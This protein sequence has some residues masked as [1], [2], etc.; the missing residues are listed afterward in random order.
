MCT[1]FVGQLFLF[2][3]QRDQ[4]PWQNTDSSRVH[5]NRDIP[6]VNR[7]WQIGYAGHVG[8]VASQMLLP[9]DEHRATVVD[10]LK[11]II[12]RQ[13]LTFSDC[14]SPSSLKDSL[15]VRKSCS[16]NV[17]SDTACSRL[18]NSYGQPDVALS[19]DY[20]SSFDNSGPQTEGHSNKGNDR[21]NIS[22]KTN[23]IAN[24]YNMAMFENSFSDSAAND[25]FESDIIPSSIEKFRKCEKWNSLMSISLENTISK[26]LPF[27]KHNHN[28][29]LDGKRQSETWNNRNVQNEDAKE[30][31]STINRDRIDT[32]SSISNVLSSMANESVA[33]EMTDGGFDGFSSE[34]DLDNL[35]FDLDIIRSSNL[36]TELNLDKTSKSYQVTEKLN[37][38]E[39]DVKNEISKDAHGSESTA[40]TLLDAPDSEDL[41]VFLANLIQNYSDSIERTQI[42]SSFSSKM[43]SPEKKKI[44]LS[45]PYKSVVVKSQ[46]GIPVNSGLR[47]MFFSE[48]DNLNEDETQ[49]TEINLHVSL[50]NIKETN[51]VKTQPSDHQ[52]ESDIATKER[53]EDS[54]SEK[55]DITSQGKLDILLLEL[56]ESSLDVSENLSVDLFPSPSIGLDC[57]QTAKC[58]TPY[59][60]RFQNYSVVESQELFSPSPVVTLPQRKPYVLYQSTPFSHK[61]LIRRNLVHSLNKKQCQS[62]IREKEK[63]VASIYDACEHSNAELFSSQS[64]QCT[65]DSNSTGGQVTHNKT[66]HI[67]SL[68]DIND[69][70][71]ALF[72][73]DSF[74]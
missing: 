69:V 29:I 36:Q 7:T 21:V 74:S 47:S 61:N 35:N 6:F 17:T 60:R 20:N 44:C 46:L 28:N 52:E 34:L 9:H 19:C 49:E 48:E 15:S 66:N 16:I 39:I 22:A 67:S 53:D 8:A 72:S 12:N 71:C 23:S 31:N 70:S 50:R 5:P 14:D 24:S 59:M 43:A 45:E 68:C 1:T 62:C 41:D 57:L 10:A 38:K 63:S 54:N 73:D 37:L 40:L 3:F 58:R 65:S 2:G 64:F 13:N 30:G 26:T 18:V 4:S 25:T 27:T 33:A 55:H 42:D 56:P 11:H 32:V 51:E